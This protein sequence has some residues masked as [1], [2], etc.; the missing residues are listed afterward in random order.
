M[1]PEDKVKMKK[2]KTGMQ[3]SKFGGKKSYSVFGGKS[4]IDAGGI[5]CR[6]PKNDRLSPGFAE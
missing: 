6:N 2:C 3:F 4:V 5:H 1:T